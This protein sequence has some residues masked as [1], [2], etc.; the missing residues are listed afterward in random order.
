MSKPS[1]EAL[2]QKVKELE[3]RLDS[4]YEGEKTYRYLFDGIRDA[5]FIHKV[6]NPKLPGKFWDVNEAACQRLGYTREELRQ[7]SPEEINDSGFASMI[8]K[9]MKS[10]M[11]KKHVLFETEHVAKDGCRIPTEVHAHVFEIDGEP[12]I[13]SIARDITERK[14]WE[15]ELRQVHSFLEHRVSDRT[16]ELEEANRKLNEEI[17]ERKEAEEALRKSEERFKAI[18]DYTYDWESWVDPEG[19]LIWVNSGVERIT[20]YTREEYMN[21]PERLRTIILAEEFNRIASYISDGL[22]NENSAND[23]PFRIRQKGGG[24]RWASMS[25]QPIYDAQGKHL[26]LRSSIRDI[27]E[28][29]EAEIEL[30]KR[31]AQYKRLVEGIP[32]ILYRYSAKNGGLFYSSRV[33]EILGYPLARMYAEPRLWNYSIHPEDRAR[34]NAAVKAFNEGQS[35]ELEYRIKNARGNWL[36]LRD[37]SI[38]RR[39]EE[40]EVIIEGLALDITARK[41]AEQEREKLTNQLRE[42]QK[43]EAIGTLAGGIAHDFNNILGAVMGYT[44][45]SIGSLSSSPETVRMLEEV[46]KAGR[47]ARDLIQQI[48]AFSRQGR[49]EKKPFRIDLVVKEVMK[50]MRATIPKTVEIKEDF[51]TDCGPVLGDP[52]QVHQVMMNLC[53]N[54]YHAMRETGGQLNVRLSSLDI[55]PPDITRELPVTPGAYVLLEVGDTGHGMSKAVQERIFDPYFTTK[56]HNEGTGMGLAVVHGIVKS[57]NGHISVYSEPGQGTTFRVLLPKAEGDGIPADTATR[58]RPPGGNE[59]I[60]VVDDEEQLTEMMQRMLEALGYKVTACTASTEALAIFTEQP[61]SFDLVITDMTM[62]NLTGAQLAQKIMKIKPATRLILCTGF[63]EIIDEEK[64]K[65]YGFR[66]YITKPVLRRDL[67]NAVRRVLDSK[68]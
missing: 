4:R 56:K 68:T 63:S 58:E 18:A 32:G 27:T 46:L 15:R 12:T 37:R 22:K 24:I 41:K 16:V 51:P 14:K 61:D 20:G 9:I 13:L 64:A 65:V 7:M 11:R 48:L 31:E 26:G 62:P 40:N 55:G 36:W 67:A 30:H 34:V 8:P 21:D 19:K 54:A 59:R 50:L 52:T 45:L 29:T 42:A 53:T 17:N 66:E 47:R 1:Y 2:E 10:L 3:A 38:G 60:L 44:E 25:Y 49:Q 39:E 28:R 23:I 57:H 35:F 5:V 6:T 33:E 43:L